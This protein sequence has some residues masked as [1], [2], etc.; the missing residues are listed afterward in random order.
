MNTRVAL[1]GGSFDPI[2]HGH[3][4]ASRG[5]AEQLHLSKVVLIPALQP[6]HKTN[7][8]ISEPQHRLAMARLAVEGDPLFE[9]SDIE[10][11]RPGPSYT[12][13]TVMAFRQALG[14]AVDLFWIIGADSL[15]ELPTWRR[16]AELVQLA[17]IVTAA[18]PGWTPPPRETLAATGGPAAAQMLL[19]HCC[20]TP[21]IDISSS[22]IRDRVRSGRS[23]RYL[24]PS[25][26]ASYIQSQRL[27]L[28]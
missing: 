1:Y 25:E 16:I 18:R 28:D 8:T 20:P 2:H 4:I 27:Y 15:P 17:K 9:V 3:L 6:P 12:I 13:D 19:N 14:P 10:L 11:H 24:V 22:D 7:R 23:I 21:R 5:I 26:V